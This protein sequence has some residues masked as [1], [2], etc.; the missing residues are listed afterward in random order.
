MTEEI[1]ADEFYD[2]VASNPET[3][4][5]FVGMPNTE[6]T[7]QKLYEF[8]KKKWRERIIADFIGVQPLSA[9]A[10]LDLTMRARYGD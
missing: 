6:E 8:I 10:G 4:Q 7:R 5:D 1:D 9:P 3:L 2:I